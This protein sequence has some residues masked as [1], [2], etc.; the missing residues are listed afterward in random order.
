MNKEV[1]R[2]LLVRPKA[3]NEWGVQDKGVLGRHFLQG[4]PGIG[5]DRADAILSKFGRIPMAWT[6]SEEEL[7]AVP[8]IGKLTSKRLWKVLDD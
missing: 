5:P 1:H 3:K 4:L 2:S 6:C 7:T 8:G